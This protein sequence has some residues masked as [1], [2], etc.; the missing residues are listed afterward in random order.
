MSDE[1][2]QRDTEA[3]LRVFF[4]VLFVYLLRAGYYSAPAYPEV[5][6]WVVLH[7]LNYFFFF[8]ASPTLA[9]PL[10]ARL[11]S[12]TMEVLE[13]QEVWGALIHAPRPDDAVEPGHSFC[14]AFVLSASAVTCGCR[15]NVS[16]RAH[17]AR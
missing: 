10:G 17:G 13:T 8:S 2:E 5:P 4:Y 11:P 7:E 3:K 9:V 14:A 6:T 15:E 12:E 1:F 16:S